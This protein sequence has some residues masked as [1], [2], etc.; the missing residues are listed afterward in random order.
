M[1][2][3][4][5]QL[6]VLKSAIL[7]ESDPVFVGYRTEGNTGLMAAWF[8]GASTFTVWRTLVQNSEVGRA[9]VASGLS[10]MTTANNDR[11]VSLALW[12]PNGVQPFRVDHRQF[13]DDVFSPVSGATTRAALLALW[14][15][16][17]TRGERLFVT[18]T[19]SDAVPGLLVF[20]GQITDAL[21][22]LAINN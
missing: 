13:F 3:T 20:E 8:N 21:V 16:F 17:A 5:A 4:T 15:R 18:G 2:L 11:L 19:G 10:A 9:F 12:N 7:A 1:S 22:V 14:K 6:T